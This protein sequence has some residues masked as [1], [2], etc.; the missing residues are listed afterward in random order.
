MK[1]RCGGANG[2]SWWGEG[3]RRGKKHLREGEHSAGM[4]R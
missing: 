2:A 3:G 4:S 1:T